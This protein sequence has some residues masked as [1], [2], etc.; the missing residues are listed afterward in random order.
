MDK[1]FKGV[2]KFREE[3]FEAH[4]ELFESLGRSSSSPWVEIRSHIHSLSA[5]QIRAL[6]RT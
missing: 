2:V 3:D 6:Y 1:L 5:V 4:K